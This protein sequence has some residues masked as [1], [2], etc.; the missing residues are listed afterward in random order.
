MWNATRVIS[1]CVQGAPQMVFAPYHLEDSD[2]NQK[3]AEPAGLFAY[4][5]SSVSS[6]QHL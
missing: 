2:D 6:V 5:C 3:A 1:A 4:V